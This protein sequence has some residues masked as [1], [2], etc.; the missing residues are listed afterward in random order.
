M[1]YII[2]LLIVTSLLSACTT[3]GG[4]MTETVVLET[5]KGNIEIQLDRENAPESVENF[6]TY[7]KEG[8]YDGT[9]FHRVI[10]DFMIQGGGFTAD[11]AEKPTHGPIK[12][13]SQNGLANKR[14][15]IAM[16]RT[17]IPDSAT[18]QF[19][20]NV[21]DNDFL[22]YQPGPGREGYAVFGK[23]TAG[24]EVVDAI[25]SVPTASKAGMDDWP[26]EDVVINKAYMKS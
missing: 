12:L 25:R 3:K 1:R 5:T 23:V 2:L 20:I 13:E 21:V 7:V 18:S 10:K 9:V 22:N 26:T 17:S 15:T 14:G 19:F 16:A 8:H 6:V 4:N 11:G 24:M